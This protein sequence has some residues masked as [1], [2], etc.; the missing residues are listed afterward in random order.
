MAKGTPSSDAVARI[1]STPVCGVDMMNATVAPFEAPARLIE[2][3]VGI[4]PQEHSGSGI[5]NIVAQN[6]EAK[7]F[8][9]SRFA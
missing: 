9:E 6:T 7:L 2:A 1:E 5:P 8:L 3:A 4:T